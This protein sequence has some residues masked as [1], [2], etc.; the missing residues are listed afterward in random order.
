MIML[1]RLEIFLRPS[2]WI[3]KISLRLPRCRSS[4]IVARRVNACCHVIEHE[5][6]D[7]PQPRPPTN[8]WQMHDVRRLE[9]LIR[10]E[11]S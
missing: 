9:E 5:L 11:I 1:Q 2:N 3:G 4:K 6:G 7:V 8:P 10:C